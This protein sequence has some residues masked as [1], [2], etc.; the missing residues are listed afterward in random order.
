MLMGITITTI[1]GLWYLCADLV[2][3]ILFPQLVSVVYIKDSNTYG[4]LAGYIVGLFFRIGGGEPLI[5][6]K[7]FIHYPFY[8]SETGEQLFPFRT[9]AMF[10]TLGTIV[11][12]SFPLKHLFEEGKLPKHY[13]IFQCIVN[14]PEETIVLK[15]PAETGE[16][17]VLHSKTSMNGG[18]KINPALKFSSDDLIARE[19]EARNSVGES[20]DVTKEKLMDTT[21]F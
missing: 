5:Y 21:G 14:I 15:E 16:L 3:V 20:S 17:S 18:G 1:Y 11:A 6:L 8:D 13:D 7:P 12:V 4:S 19:R 10:V 9:L 2:Y